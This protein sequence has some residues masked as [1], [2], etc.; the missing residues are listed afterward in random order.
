[1]TKQASPGP[2]GQGDQD[3]WAAFGYLVAGVAFYGFIG[4]ALGRWLHAAYLVPIGLVVGMLFGMYLV[5]ARYVFRGDGSVNADSAT[6]KNEND[7]AAP[8]RPGRD[9]RGDEK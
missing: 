6:T 1:M 5:F 2:P 8:E 4:W 3:P 9:D 7:R